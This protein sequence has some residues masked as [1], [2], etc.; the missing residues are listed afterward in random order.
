MHSRAI[1]WLKVFSMLIFVVPLK[2]ISQTDTL[3]TDT[4]K[5]VPKSSRHS[6]YSGIG[7]GSN[8]IYMGSTISR[9][10]P[11][12]YAA[13]TYGFNN[14]F[15]ASLSAVHLTDLN[16]FLAFYAGSM[17]YNHVFNSWLDI[18]AGMYRYQVA[19]SLT[20]SLFSN[21]SY[22]DLTLGID[23]RLIYSKISAGGLLSDENRA[24]FQLKN[25]RYFQTP[26]F[27][28]DKVYLSFDPY[29]NLLFGTLIE[30][31]TTTGTSLRV[32][33][34]YGRWKSFIQSTT[35]NSY[36]RKFGFMEVDFGLP[37]AFN[38]DFMTV[39]AELSYILPVYE[40][41]DFP[42]SKGFVFMLSANFRIF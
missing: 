2:G 8:M 5:S 15:Y 37:V 1:S 18:S 22:G 26:G 23:W 14:E 29:V 42:G 35:Y 28:K 4:L 13:L 9:N 17:S 33:P 21:F 30:V 7:Y 41:S 6:F 3:K 32:S 27:F 25:S 20:D 40:D 10:Q 31:E 16:P 39:E 12:E 11:F 19:P 24:Y 36:T 38:S 34:P